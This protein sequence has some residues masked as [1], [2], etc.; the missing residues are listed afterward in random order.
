[1][2]GIRPVQPLRRA[3]APVIAPAPDKAAQRL[4]QQI[5]FC[6]APDGVRLAYAT[7]GRGPPLVKAANWLGDLEFD[8]DSPVWRHWI[9]ALAR[10]HCFLRYDAR[11][12]G[13]SDRVAEDL[14][15]EA[16]VRDF[17]AVVDASGFERFPIVGI[18]AGAPLA[19]AYAA[20]HPERVSHLVLH[21]AFV[22]GPARRQP[23][24]EQRDMDESMVRLI[25]LGWGQE[26]PSFRQL[27]TSQFIPDGTPDQ[28]RWF[29]ELERVATSPQTAAKLLRM[30]YGLDVTALAAKVSCPTLVL[31]ATGDARVPF[32]EGRLIASLIPGARFVPI[33]SNNHLLLEHEPAWRRWGEEVRA[34]LPAPRADAFAALTAR[35]R[36]LLDLIA[37][38]LANPQIAARLSL[39]QKTVKN[40]VTSILA[41]LGIGS[42]ARAIVLARDAGLG[43]GGTA[44]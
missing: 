33:A 41:K 19:I 30:M 13:L 44:D 22:R 10:D 43:R 14:S 34:F 27:F 21:G 11:G 3:P 18:S 38:G 2:G 39:S 7:V 9:E 31:H 23:S 36:E 28:H 6:T 32:D 8:W 20:R 24:A 26:N 37:Q 35:E 5:R 4:R 17:E 12:C 1:M 29:N 15:F 40:H 16:L 25:E 42:R